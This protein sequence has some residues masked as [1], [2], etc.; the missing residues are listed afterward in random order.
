[1]EDINAKLDLLELN[2]KERKVAKEKF[3]VTLS[4][5]SYE[6]MQRIVDFLK[7]KDIHITK[8]R[9][10]KVLCNDFSEITKNYS[11]IESINE[12]DLYKE[13]PI[14]LNNNALD[15]YKRIKYCMQIGMSY[16][17]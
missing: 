11:I 9:E 6:E 5:V 7:L 3:L 16:Y 1:M 14:R 17:E 12:V 4:V 13:D 10:L 2:D 8:A 15:I